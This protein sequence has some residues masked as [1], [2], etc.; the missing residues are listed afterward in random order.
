MSKQA[1]RT[2]A[3]SANRRFK[4]KKSCQFFIGV[5][6]EALSVVAMCIRDKERPP[7]GINR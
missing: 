6:N 7:F 4:F 5:H 1:S 3:A 2:F